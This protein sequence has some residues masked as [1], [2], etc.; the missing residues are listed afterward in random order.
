VEEDRKCNKETWYY[1][2]TSWYTSKRHKQNCYTEWSLSDEET[3]LHWDEQN[4][5]WIASE[6]QKH[7]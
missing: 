6:L 5:Q 2:I 4:W 7:I 3:C 1:T